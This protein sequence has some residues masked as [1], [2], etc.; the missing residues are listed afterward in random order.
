M[1]NYNYKLKEKIFGFL[2]VPYIHVSCTRSWLVNDKRLYRVWSV[3]HRQLLLLPE[4]RGTLCYRNHL[5]Y[6]YVLNILVSK[7]LE[8]H[9]ICVSSTRSSLLSH[10]LYLITLNEVRMQSLSIF[11][12]PPFDRCFFVSTYC[13]CG[14]YKL[15]VVY[16]YMLSEKNSYK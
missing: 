11:N 2:Y 15:R 5:L 12:I 6:I 7:S 10:V 4:K 14:R 1:Q 9:C 3:C 13:F 8:A 16:S